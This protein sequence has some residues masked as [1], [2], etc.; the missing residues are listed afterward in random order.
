MKKVEL[1]RDVDYHGKSY[2]EGDMIELID[3]VADK[4]CKRGYAK[5]YV[6]EETE[7]KVS[8]PSFKKKK[9]KNRSHSSG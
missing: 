9:R 3:H 8:Q 5:P 2:N 7:E 4:F 6:K 1:L